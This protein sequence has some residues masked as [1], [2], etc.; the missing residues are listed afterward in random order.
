ML[1]NTFEDYNTSK[2]YGNDPSIFYFGSDNQDINSEDL[3]NEFLSD[4]KPFELENQNMYEFWNY[5]NINQIQDKLTTFETNNKYIILEFIRIC[6]MQ[7]FKY[8]VNYLK[9]TNI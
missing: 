8:L 1:I 7:S 6:V 3:N 2:L 9:D 5:D 4:D